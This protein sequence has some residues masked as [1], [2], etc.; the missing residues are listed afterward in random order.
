MLA[1]V[2]ARIAGLKA[3]GRLTEALDE[4]GEAYSALD[5]N[6]HLLRTLD[7]GSIAR[8]LRDPPRVRGVARLLA[9][10]A[11]LRDARGERGAAYGQRRRA[12]ELCKTLDPAEKDALVLQLMT[13]LE[14]KLES[15]D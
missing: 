11:D 7:A 2:F 10:E 4:V 5:L 13:E 15:G 8:M 3:E 9:E 1:A 6:P 14:G 12:L